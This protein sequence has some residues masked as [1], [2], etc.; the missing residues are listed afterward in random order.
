M[1]E[2]NTDDLIIGQKQQREEGFTNGLEDT[3]I[4]TNDTVELNSNEVT[5]NRDDDQE[6][7]FHNGN[8]IVK[9]RLSDDAVN[10]IDSRDIPQKGEKKI[11]G[12]EHDGPD[13]STTRGSKLDVGLL[14]CIPFACSIGG[15]GTLTG[16]DLNLYLAGFHADMY[17]TY[18]E[19]TP[20]G[21]T[22]ELWTNNGTGK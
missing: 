19:V 4:I 20:D 1:H 18:K 7:S 15:V 17:K 9:P 8:M 22:I 3:I 2:Y 14:L 12:Y 16:T 13:E 6:T 10:V 11:S 21:Q 5:S